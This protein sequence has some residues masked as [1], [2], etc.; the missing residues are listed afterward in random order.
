M[1]DMGEA[2]SHPRH[3]RHSRLRAKGTLSISQAECVNSILERFGMTHCNLGHTPGYGSE[4]SN[5]Q[6]DKSLRDTYGTNLYQAMVRSTDAVPHSMRTLRYE[7]RCTP[8]FAR[9]CSHPAQAHM[10]ASKHAVK[11]LKG[12]LSLPI[13]Y[14][15]GQFR[16]QGYTDASFAS[17]PDPRKS[18][19]GFVFFL[20]GVSISFG[21]KTQSPTAQSTV[22]AEL[23]AISYTTTEAVYLSTLI[24]EQHF[25]R[26]RYQQFQ[27]KSRKVQR[28]L[29]SAENW[30]ELGLSCGLRR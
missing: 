10:T 19:A 25:K 2:K 7:L 21:A 9:A 29:R 6:P 30:H 11:Y 20:S 23:M 13:I 27:N 28:L 17:N 4:L 14:K 3:E 22:E 16:M 5:E 15:R 12:H 8:A 18:T 1:T 26:C 24:F